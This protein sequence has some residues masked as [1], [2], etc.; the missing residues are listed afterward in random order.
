MTARGRM[1]KRADRPSHLRSPMSH[2]P[3][4]VLTLGNAIVDVLAQTDEAFLVEQERP[5]GRH[6]AHRRG[7]G[8]GALRRH[9]S[10][11]RSSPAARPPTRPRASRP[12][13][14]KAGFIG[15]VKDDE[16]GR[17]FAHDL[18]A[19]DVHYDVALAKDGPGDGAQLHPGD[20]RRRAHHEHLSGRLPEPH[21]RRRRSRTV[22]EASSIVYLEGYL[23]DPPAAKEA[24]RKAV[25]IAHGA[26][27]QGGA[28]PL[29]RI[30]RRPLPRR[31]PGPH[32]RR[33]P[34]HPV[35]QHPRT[36]EPVTDRGRRHGPR[37][38]ARGERSSASSPGRPTAPS[39]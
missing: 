15:K 38:P 26:G 9:G 32:P 18:N 33:Q 10:G 34:R 37:G 35:R 27:N 22:V 3:I 13:A 39:W 24:F 25:G 11:H 17:L 21:A 2:P 12:S 23:W 31:V 4:D 36:A 28:D 5:Q 29:G 8:R 7:P 1:R 6:A 19:I 16:T 30:L 20:A 14:C